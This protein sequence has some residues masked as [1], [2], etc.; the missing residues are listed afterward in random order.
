VQAFF[1]WLNARMKKRNFLFAFGMLLLSLQWS[2]NDPVEELPT[3]TVFLS[4]FSTGPQGWSPFF[5]DLPV[6]AELSYNLRID[7]GALPASTGIAGNGLVISGQN[8]GQE[9]YIFLKK[10]VSGL[11]PNRLYN[12]RFRVDLATNIIQLPGAANKS[13]IENTGTSL[14]AGALSFEPGI[15]RI[16]PV[17]GLLEP[18]FNHRVSEGGGNRTGDLINLGPVGHNGA[19][20]DFKLLRLDNINTPFLARAN[21]EGHIW[22]LLGIHTSSK[23]ELRLY[24]RSTRILFNGV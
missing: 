18:N 3:G 15:Q 1:L 16:S 24:L 4:D 2:C 12:I 10:E 17:S 23:E 11:Q 9:L 19:S 7:L 8:K 6:N 13:N 20:P 21:D 22:I 14:V 5:T